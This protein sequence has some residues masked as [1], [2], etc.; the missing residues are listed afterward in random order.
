MRMLLNK[1]VKTAFLFAFDLKAKKPPWMVAFIAYD[2]LQSPKGELEKDKQSRYVAL[3]IGAIDL[4][5]LG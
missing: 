5:E 4:S 3:L 2:I 1:R